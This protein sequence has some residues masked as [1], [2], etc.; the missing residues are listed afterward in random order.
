MRWFPTLILAGFAACTVDPIGGGPGVKHDTSTSTPDEDTAEPDPGKDP[1]P[2]A[3]VPAK[4]PGPIDP[5]SDPGKD[6]PAT[7]IPDVT[8]PGDTV[9]DSP[10]ETTGSD[11]GYTPDLALDPDASPLTGV[12]TLDPQTFKFFG[13]PVD[14]LRFAMAGLDPA[15]HVCVT[16]IWDFSNLGMSLG[17][18]CDDFKPGF[19]YTVVVPGTDGPCQAWDLGPNAAF[20][21]AEGCVD[22]ALIGVTNL[23]LADVKVKVQSNAFVG[24]IVAD[25]R[26]SAVPSPVSFGIEYTSDVPDHVFVQTAGN[27][28][29]PT[30]IQV[31]KNGDPVLI[32][33]PCDTPTCGKPKNPC[34]KPQHQVLDFVGGAFSGSIYQTWDG[35]VRTFDTVNKCYEVKPAE[36]GEYT[37]EFCLSWKTKT[38]ETGTDVI[39]AACQ[40]LQFTYPTDKVVYKNN[41]GG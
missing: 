31:S 20:V 10:A 24:T 17:P 41:S 38:G 25:N 15:R 35:S 6:V 5:G 33:D 2:V 21:S 36:A 3:D 13:L 12:L 28:G 11:I 22:F 34:G 37:A 4:D 30:W 7:E 40:Q 9:E 32:F 19:P 39:E 27:Q 8:D 29:L 18:H 26:S 1:G 16:L 14:S 23:D